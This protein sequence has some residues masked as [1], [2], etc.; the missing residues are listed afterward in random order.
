MPQSTEGVLL[1]IGALFFLIGLLGGGFEVSAIK[2]PPIEKYPRA[3]VFGMGILLLLAGLFRILFPA[4]P[5]IVPAANTAVA[6]ITVP[7][8][9][10]TPLPPTPTALP[11]TVTPLPPTETPAPPTATATVVTATP[12]MTSTPSLTSSG[13]IHNIT[14]DYK[15][16][17]FGQEGMLIH[18]KFGVVGMNGVKGRIL[19]YFFDDKG[20]KLTST[21]NKDLSAD[22]LYKYQASD[23]QLIVWDYFTPIYDDAEFNDF[24]LFMPYSAIEVP[25]GLHSLAFRVYLRDLRGAGQNIAISPDY[26]FELSK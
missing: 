8:P 9:T 11:P 2:I 18:V 6:V 3:V 15:V 24:Q 16:T 23:G 5:V 13:T 4:S 19:A 10:A 21:D 22:G 1:V 14:V 12:A 20:Q 7:P 25:A 26:S 17:Q